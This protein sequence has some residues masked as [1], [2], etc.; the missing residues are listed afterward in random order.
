MAEFIAGPN[1]SGRSAALMTRLRE[2][3]PAFFVGPYAEGGAVG[4]FQHGR[5]R[6]RHLSRASD[7]ASGLRAARF[8]RLCGAQAADAL[9][10]RAG[11]CSRCIASRCRTMRRS[12]STR[13]SSSSIPDNRD[14]AL[15]YLSQGAAHGFTA[16][17][18]DNRLACPPGWSPRELASRASEFACDLAATARLAPRAAP[19]IGVQQLVL[20][21]FRRPRH[22]PQRRTSRSNPATPIASPVRTAP[23]R[24]RC[25]SCSRASSAPS[26]GAITLDGDRLRA[27]AQRQPHLRARDPEPGP[28]VVRR[29]LVGG[30]GA[31]ARRARAHSIASAVPMRT[32]RRLRPA[33]ASARWTSTSMN[34]RWSRANA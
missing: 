30:S 28:P 14:A 22:F 33:S 4:P 2:L 3:A 16:A 26:A 34:C 27:V 18:I 13:R 15:A 17:L 32:S 11:A 6:D 21:L 24:P 25:S 10:W 1:F 29:D 23:A 20:P 12:A 19:T 8:C 31:P 5:G 9:G 7:Q